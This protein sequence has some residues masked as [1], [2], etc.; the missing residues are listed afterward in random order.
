MCQTHD[1]F[2]PYLVKNENSNICIISIQDINDELEKLIDEH[3]VKITEGI[4]EQERLS[5]AKKELLNFFEK[6]DKNKKIGASA[7]FFIHLYLNKIGFEQLCL[8]SNLEE[9]SVKKGFDGY[10]L[11]KSNT[12]IM[13]SKSG[14]STTT[15]I[16]HRSKVQKAYND[17]SNKLK[18]IGSNNTW[19][20]ALNHAKMVKADKNI[21]KELQD[22]SD[23]FINGDKKHDIADFNII[24]CS[25]IFYLD[26]WT[27]EDIKSVG[28]TIVE[29]ISKCS[30]KNI[31]VICLNKASV[32]AFI[33]YLKKGHK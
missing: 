20:N 30:Y 6:K 24:P 16:S 32:D 15:D 23:K 25:T 9:E 4:N 8:F 2:N 26:E 1:F 13:E 11:F 21:L 29:Y 14:L 3:L 10:Y 7:E 33:N 5:I 31:H 27:P 17:L 12:W 28:N 22:F 19:R 18:G